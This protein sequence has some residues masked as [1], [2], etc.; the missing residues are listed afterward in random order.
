[1]RQLIYALRFTGR[2]VPASLAPLVLR[3]ATTAVGPAGVAAALRLAGGGRA[4]CESEATVSDDHAFHACGTI[5]FDDGGH[6]LRFSTI[7]P[8]YLGPSAELGF[9]AG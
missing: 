1:M 4:R 5:A 3:A 7:D 8:G 9:A 6:R 2:A